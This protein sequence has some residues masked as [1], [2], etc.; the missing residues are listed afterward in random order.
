MTA[1]G[2]AMYCGSAVQPLC[3]M[4]SLS[5]ASSGWPVCVMD[6]FVF[7]RI[8]VLVDFIVVSYS[9]NFAGSAS[10]T[11]KLRT[12]FN[13]GV[14]DLTSEDAYEHDIHSV[15]DVVKVRQ[16]SISIG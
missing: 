11:R 5:R 10:K 2:L 14:V 4:D 16:L 12:C 13:S 15:A 1:V 7:F 3:A 6:R 8:C 9:N